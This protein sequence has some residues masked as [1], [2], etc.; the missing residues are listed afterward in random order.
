M[1][2]ARERGTDKYGD[3]QPSAEYLGALAAVPL[4]A[5][6]RNRPST[7]FIDIIITAG[8][9]QKYG[10]GTAY[11]T[12]PTPMDD[13]RFT[14][15]NPAVDPLLL[16]PSKPTSLLD[17]GAVIS[18]LRSMKLD[19]DHPQQSSPDL[20]LKSHMASA[21]TS[22]SPTKKAINL[23]REFGFDL[24]IAEGK[25]LTV[26]AFR[27]SRGRPNKE[28]RS[29]LQRLGDVKKMNEQNRVKV[30][31][32][33]QKEISDLSESVS[34]QPPVQEQERPLKRARTDSDA[35]Y[36]DPSKID[37]RPT[38]TYLYPSTAT[39]DV[40]RTEP[41]PKHALTQNRIDIALDSGAAPSGPLL[42]RIGS[43]SPVKTPRKTQ[44]AAL[45][46]SPTRTAIKQQQKRRSSATS[47]PEKAIPFI[48]PPYQD[49]GALPST[50][51]HHTVNTGVSPTESSGRGANRTATAWNPGEQSF[52]QALEG[53]EE[54]Q[55]FGRNCCVR[56]AKSKGANR[57]IGKARGGV[58]RE[59]GV[60]VGVRFCVW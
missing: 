1:S 24:T 31:A 20:Q 3:L 25:L 39:D 47:S 12:K 33:L 60:V 8:K 17:G 15:S 6:V 43:A 7:G 28:G 23:A 5:R 2:Q 56:F 35:K 26:T 58:F 46:Y 21:S 55:A 37:A 38:K 59:D 27:N 29:L 42:R 45:A 40:F 44:A 49:T 9:G 22:P 10:P 18:P 51:P 13:S 30:L 14:T 41:K 48:L 36:I 53:F 32:K 4:P 52:T 19:A 11:L 50:P 16:P 54:R 34:N 57:Q